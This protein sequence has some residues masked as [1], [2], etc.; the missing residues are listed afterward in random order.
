MSGTPKPIAEGSLASTPFGHVLLSIMRK[1]MNGTLAVWPEDE[2]QGQDRIRFD[3]GVPTAGRFLDPAAN[4]ERGLLTIFQREQAPFAFY[5]ADLVGDSEA[6]IRGSV[7]PFHTIA[8]A[9]R[10]AP[11]SNTITRVVRGLGDDQQRVKRGAPLNRFSLAPTEA[12]FVDFM[13]AAPAAPGQ[14]ISEFGD[15]EVARRMLYL[16]AVTDNL[17]VYKTPSSQQKLKATASTQ[18]SPAQRSVSNGS[19]P[20]RG[21]PS[22]SGERIGVTSDAPRQSGHFRPSTPP[23]PDDVSK[24]VLSGEIVAPRDFPP[25]PP[26]ELSDEARERWDE[27][28]RVISMMDRQNYFEMLGCK[29]SSEGSEVRT[30]Y[31]QL[32]KKWHP[33]RMPAELAPVRPWVEEIFHL[34]TVASDTLTDEK[35]RQG[36]QKTVMQ[37]GGTPEADRKI[38][39]VV[40]TALEFQKVEV[41]VKRRRYDEAMEI[42]DRALASVKKEADYPAMKAWIIFLRDGLDD[43]VALEQIR[44]NLRLTFKLNRDHTHGHFVRAH[45]LKRLGNHDKALA[46]FKKVVKL[47]PK[48]LEALR[49]VRVA[50]MRHSKGMSTAPPP[51]GSGRRPS[52]FGG[53][54]GKKK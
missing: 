9:L 35:S 46:H 11:P 17:E 36:Y 41:L 28:S 45:V 19:M 32:A 13:R 54:F 51:S 23:S 30:K 3:D 42:V 52:I 2:R 37:G 18:S 24:E 48:N 10:D 29:E 53:L 12:A 6:T 20:A 47:D 1:Q 5:E 21:R 44:A 31:L 33:D 14:L 26:A 39:V 8:A 16:L 22:S 25:E 27:V 40:N 34:L 7:D 43:P 15:P 49:E 4:L 38:N 50:V